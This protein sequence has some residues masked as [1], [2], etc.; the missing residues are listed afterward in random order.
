MKILIEL[1]TWIG[2]AVMALPAIENIA[3][4]YTNSQI[5]IVGSMASVEIIDNHPQVVKTYI[6]KNK[7]S[8]L[9]R[10]LRELNEFDIFLSF[11]NSLRA[12]MFKA[13]ISSKRKF[14][15]NKNKYPSRHQVEKYNSFV[16]E[17][18]NLN[19]EAGNLKIYSQTPVM[20]SDKKY[21]GINPGASY[22]S[23]K[24]WYS[25]EFAELA[26]KLAQHYEIIIF[27]ASEEKNIANEIEQLL[28]MKGVTNYSNLAGK[29]DIKG[30]IMKISTLSLFI[31]G[32]SGPMHIAAAFQ[33]PTVSIFG[34]TRDEE[35]SQW[36]NN[37][38]IIVKKNLDCQPCMKRTCPLGHH[39]CMKLIR[40][41]EIL[42]AVKS[43]TK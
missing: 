31:T 42:D 18:L 41:S 28:I 26:K 32:D 13:F 22:G 5:T 37:K 21:L 16:N 40:A 19:L 20:N 17:S 33:V 25:E 6:L 4:S 1:P 35:T 8:N 27:G 34:P 2:D 39:N 7:H 14:Q 23:S 12:K 30:L 3:N 29:T 11:R 10:I 36:K 38:N 9:F 43:I 15:F 24:R